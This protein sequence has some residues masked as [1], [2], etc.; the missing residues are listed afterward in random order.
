MKMPFDFRQASTRNQSNNRDWD[1]FN[2]KFWDS[3]DEE[4]GYVEEYAS[5]GYV[6]E[7]YVE[8]DYVEEDYVEEDYDV[9]EYIEDTYDTEYAVSG[10]NDE[11]YYED[12][13]TEQDYSEEEYDDENYSGEEEYEEE[14][15]E[16][17]YEER[18]YTEEE[19]LSDEY[20]EEE[21]EEEY[22]EESYD[23]Y[24]AQRRKEAGNKKSGLDYL[25]IIGAAAVF[26]LAL[27]LCG[28]LV[29]QMS[30]KDAGNP[31]QGVGSQL[32]GI[33]LIGEQGLLAMSD[34]QKALSAAVEDATA[35]PTPTPPVYDEEDMDNKVVVKLSVTSIEKDLKLK[36]LNQ[37]TAKLVGNVPFSVEATDE[38]GKSYFWSDDDMDGIIYKKNLTPG[39]YTIA[40]NELTESKYSFVSIADKEKTAAVKDVIEYEKVDVSD[41]ILDESDVDVEDED[42]GDT[43]TP[44][45]EYLEDTVPWVE[46][47][48]TGGTYELVGKDKLKDPFAVAMGN[49]MK[50]G[51]M[52]ELPYTMRTAASEVPE[53]TPIPESEPTPEPVVTAEPS[54]TPAP[55]PNV[56]PSPTPEPTPVPTESP[57]P[58][59]TDTPEPVVSA[60]PSPT[61][62]PTPNVVP[63]PSPTPTPEPVSIELSEKELSLFIGSKAETIIT[64]KNKPEDA[65]LTVEA[66]TA[67]DAAI[68]NVKAESETGT[69]IL[70]EGKAEG[71]AA[72]HIKYGTEENNVT[73]KLVVKVRSSENKLKDSEGREVYVREGE[74]YRLAVYGDYY[75]NAQFYILTEPKYT[76]WQVIDGKY[77]YYDPTGKYVTGVQ[78]IQGIKHTF[79][80]DGFLQ[81]GTTSAGTMGIDVSK[82]NGTINWT[83]VKNAGVNYVIIRCGYRG[84]ANGKLIIDSKYE[85]NIKGAI[86]AGLKVG[87]YFFSQAT[88]K[89]EAIEEA[90][91]VL[92]CIQDYKI[93]YPVFLDVEPSG[94]RADKLSKAE[95][96]EICKAFCETIQKYGYTAGIYANKNWLENK[97]DMSVLNSYKVWLAQ[98]ASEPTYRGRYD[99]WQYK[100][101]GK[102]NGISGNVDL[103]M[104]YLNY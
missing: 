79:D 5:D 77:R 87:V 40:V 3:I 101:T 104:S 75:T 80:Q 99:M 27:L 45:E 29:L 23:E 46:S 83:A 57:T 20:Y 98:Y 24:R 35:T 51:R 71:D 92:E 94:G 31:Y 74:T 61:P 97:I 58:V 81:I 89:K 64:V 39:D 100:D 1:D 63:S 30:R 7:D 32:D 10:E 54:P 17:E 52:P 14:Y 85:E 38:S 93:T 86:N 8:E 28:N 78:V 59:P 21:P 26:L 18:E 47:T 65:K 50:A 95:R 90:S 22:Y 48:V 66:V 19:Y 84:S 12:E 42:T 56:A 34:A 25:M 16:E 49:V 91:M 15:Y 6:E 76:G 37:D 62:A 72:F 36:F 73:V 33:V 9:E 96:T 11:E 69:K 2:K 67:A 70:V 53:I 60:E 55:T 82:W 4:D 88:D 103:N 41:E 102:I 68:A 43:D 44:A 13:Y